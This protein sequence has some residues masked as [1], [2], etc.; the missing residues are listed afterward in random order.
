M[1][2]A[3]LSNKNFEAI[4]GQVIIPNDNTNFITN[5]QTS[6]IFISNIMKNSE[7][8]E[9]KDAKMQLSIPRRPKWNDKIS[10]KE[11]DR[12]EREAFL[13]WRKYLAEEEEK[14]INLVLTPFEKNPE[15]WKQ[16]WLVMEKADLL[17]QI[18]DSRN[19]YF[20]RSEDL[21]TAIKEKGKDYFML[22]NKADL[23]NDKMRKHWSNYFKEKGIN[24]AF[25]SALEEL[26]KYDL[27]DEKK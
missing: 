24:Y 12:L 5:N 11:F 1:Q 3:S 27:I 7:M 21:E 17:I 2:L 22:V 18:V 26:N 19:P 6:K 23:L 4:K 20:F 8:K 9:T 16:L 14:N 25:F 13:N 10:A 15:V